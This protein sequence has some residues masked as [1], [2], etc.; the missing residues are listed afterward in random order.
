AIQNNVSDSVRNLLLATK[1][2]QELLKQWSIGQATETQISNAY[3][4]IGENF[5]AAIKAFAYYRVDLRCVISQTPVCVDSFAIIFSDIYSVPEDLRKPLERMLVNQPSPQ[6][7][8]VHMPEIRR[9]LYKLYK[10][11][12]IRRDLWRTGAEGQMSL[13]R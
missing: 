9:A 10:G 1:R 3:V 4:K 7:L 5:N 11:I 6:V 13:Y 8:D 2:L 12:H